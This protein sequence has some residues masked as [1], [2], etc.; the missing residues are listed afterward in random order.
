MF[1]GRFFFLVNSI[2]KYIF[3]LL[4]EIAHLRP[5][6]ES[7]TEPSSRRTDLRFLYSRG[8]S[9]CRGLKIYFFYAL[10]RAF[11]SVELDHPCVV[12]SDALCPQVL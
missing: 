1:L 4:C 5:V 9:L 10:C 7:K 8:S 3:F 11:R 2:Y 6:P 12:N